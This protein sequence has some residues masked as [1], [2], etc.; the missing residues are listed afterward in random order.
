MLEEGAKGNANID[1]IEAEAI[2]EAIQYT[3]HNFAE[4]LINDEGRV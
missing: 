4:E 1:M 2:A 3:I